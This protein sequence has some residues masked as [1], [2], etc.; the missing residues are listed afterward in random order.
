MTDIA[1]RAITSSYE[2]LSTPSGLAGQHC[3]TAPRHEEGEWCALE[4]SNLWPSDS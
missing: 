4:D 1:N 3:I 2:A